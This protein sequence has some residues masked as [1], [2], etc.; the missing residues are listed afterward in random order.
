MLPGPQRSRADTFATLDNREVNFPPKLA[1]ANQAAE[2]GNMPSV[3]ETLKEALKIQS[4]LKATPTHFTYSMALS[5][6]R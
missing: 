6:L 3:F 2:A 4:F 1:S 5:V